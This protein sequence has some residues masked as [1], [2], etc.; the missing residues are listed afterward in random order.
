MRTALSFILLVGI[1]AG[2]SIAQQTQ[3]RDTLPVPDVP[4]YKTLKCDFH[5]HT[6]FSDGD[7]WP[8]V[9]V[10]EAF[11][12]G[13]DAIAITDHA[14]YN[15]HKADIKVDLSRPDAIAG[16]TARQLGIILIPAI[17]V[18]AGNIHYNA[19][20][21]KDQNALVGV[22]LKEALTR[23]KAQ[24]AFA[25]WNHPGW[26]GTAEWFP[27][28]AD[29]YTSEL[30]QGMELLNGPNFYPEAYPWIEEKKLTILA[31]SDV[32]RPVTDN[33]EKRRRPVTLVFAKT[34]DEAGIK[35]ALLARRT[36]AWM[37]GEVYGFS[38]QLA[39]LWSGAVK[40]EPAVF[41]GVPGWGAAL[42]L[43]N[44]SAIPF[45]IKLKSAPAW[46][47]ARGAVVGPEST[48]GIALSIAKNA[49]AGT[50]KVELEYEVTNFHTGPG[51]T[52]TVKVPVTINIGA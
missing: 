23:A 41:S 44:T 38:E 36:A 49:P 31:N 4:G 1:S 27:I 52:L 3:V 40:A 15:P 16:S 18:N 33:Y 9:R 42:R 28:V 30:F 10:I 12:D 37:N 35:E 6:V 21:L 2:P 17:E 51:S 7:V 47:S 50:H 43:R 20:F 5:M 8:T 26:K 14:A 46:I 19:L 22:E 13:L 24:G 45:Q 39:A 48:T 32:H 34:A 29:L 11:R 25:F